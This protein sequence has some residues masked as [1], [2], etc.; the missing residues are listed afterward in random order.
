MTRKSFR[1]LNRCLKICIYSLNRT[2]TR[3]FIWRNLVLHDKLFGIEAFI[4]ELVDM[5]KSVTPKNLLRGFLLSK[6][7]PTPELVI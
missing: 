1:F 7:L 3:S 2:V 6:L 5:R 4:I